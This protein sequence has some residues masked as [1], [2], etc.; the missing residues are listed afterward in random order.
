MSLASHTRTH[1]VHRPLGVEHPYAD[2]PDQRVPAIPRVGQP[3]RLGLLAPADASGLVVEVRWSSGSV[4][5]LPLHQ[6]GDEPSD[7]A[8]LAGGDGHLSTAQ[9]GALSSDDAWAVELPPL[10][11]EAGRYRFV[12]DDLDPTEWF[13]LYPAAWSV[14]R[15]AAVTG[16]PEHLV[17]GSVQALR[18][19]AGVH[20]LSFSLRLVPG[21]HVV[22]FGERFDAVDQAGRRPDSVVFEQYKSQGEYRRTYLPMPFA[23]VISTDGTS[24]GFH[25]RTARRV[26][27]DVA[28]SDPS[29]LTVEVDLGKSSEAVD[30]GVYTG[31]PAQVLSKFLDE[32]GR[33]TELPAWV[34]KLWA[35]GNE[36]NS[37]AA[38]E[39]VVA[40]HHAEDIPIGAVVIEAWSDEQSFTTFNDAHYTPH[41]DGTP[42]QASD[43]TYPFD[44]HWPD[45]AGMVRKLHEADIRV[46]LWTIPLQGDEPDFG[47]EPLAD[48]RIMTE[49][50]Y[51]VQEDDGRPYRNR[52]WWFP[53]A[54]MPD[55]TNPEARAWWLDKRRWLV[56]DL[57]IDGFKTDG[58]EHAWGSDLLYANG[59]RGDEG[60]NRYPVE[61]AAAFGELLRSEDRAPV[62]FSRAGYTG[63]QAHGVVWAGD[64][65][66]TWDAFRHSL[67]AGITAAACGIVYWSWDIAG[68]SGPVP[69]AELYLRATAASAFLPVMQYHSEFNHHRTPSRDR[70][71]WNVAEQSNDPRV[72]PLFRRYT[73]LR[74]RLI[75]YLA[76]SARAAVTT[77]HPLLRG[78]FFDWPDD[79][80]AWDFP[81]QF[82]CGNDLLVHPV[83]QPGAS[84]WTTWLPAGQ[85]V[86]VWTGEELP[87]G[88][89]HTRA[90]PLDILP[91]YCRASAWQ[92]LGDLFHPSA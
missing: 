36:W 3:L 80:R 16:A 1:L 82:L 29:L 55:F 90:V 64:E 19:G 11:S 65:N 4:D 30:V 37:Q 68:F 79:E 75:D 17:P 27:F 31:T 12:G 60:N 13:D 78:L 6:V 34:L 85:W 20:R 46:L 48:A 67:N 92:E 26:W 28:A 44:G 7:A 15:D 70:T 66:S 59:S 14:A 69:D 39:A 77:D 23:H 47:A 61:Y 52:G 42:H 43:F 73:L 10:T 81:H 76:A 54:L 62:T 71:P 24:W 40:R 51:T 89:L 88:A 9:A 86:D 2:S 74:E 56:R 41:L 38:V 84:E 5:R 91:V 22:G 21:D 25:I 49:R 58:G 53:G 33:A 18:S 35:S 50:G 87:G 63:S 57:G 83:T 8:A 72:V 45:P 32:V